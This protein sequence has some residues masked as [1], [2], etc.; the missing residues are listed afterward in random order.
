[1][2]RLHIDPHYLSLLQE[3]DLALYEQFMNCSV[4]DMIDSDHR[5]DIQK[6]RFGDSNY[7]LKRT[8]YEKTSSAL[9]SYLSGK[10]AHAKPFKEMLQISYLRQHGFDTAEV[11]AAGEKLKF[12]IPSG[13][14]ILTKEVSGEELSEKFSQATAEERSELLTQFSTLLGQLH[15]QGFFLSVRLKDLFYNAQGD[16]PKLILIDREA[17]NPAPKN[18]SPTRAKESLY[19]SNR[20]QV[21]AGDTLTPNELKQIIK[22]YCREIADTWAIAPS[23]LLK[24]LREVHRMQKK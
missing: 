14:F 7:Y 22:G 2:I 21:R 8:H 17:R 6:L 16:A 19:T 11:A 13:G 5:R 12:G 3:Q 1:M 24:E 15:R 20:R 10:L 9:E 4:G 18:F 23:V